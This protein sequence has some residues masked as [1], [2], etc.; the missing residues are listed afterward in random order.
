VTVE[1]DDVTELLAALERHGVR[2]VL[3]GSMA[4]AAQGVNRATEDI[5]FFVDPSPDNVTRLRKALKEVYEDEAVEEITSDDLAG[6][7]PVIRY[8]PPNDGFVIDLI[9]RLGQAYQFSDLESEEVEIEG[10]RIRVATPRLL[11]EMKRDTIRPQ[12]RADAEALRRRFEL[13]D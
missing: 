9:G 7:Y 10:I 3:I 13:E 12:D 4:M 5:D 6:S 1:W 11:Y 8:G 2:Y